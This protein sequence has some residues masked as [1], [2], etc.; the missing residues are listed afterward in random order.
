[1][2]VKRGRG[3]RIF[4][5]VFDVRTRIVSTWA[6]PDDRSPW[7]PCLP[8]TI[9]PAPARYSSA[10]SNTRATDFRDEIQAIS[11]RL[12]RTQE[13]SRLH[14]GTPLTATRE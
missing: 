6:A 3:A 2:G 9:V 12:R 8:H 11:M 7:V 5:L 4:P 10:E 13:P 14:V 1:V